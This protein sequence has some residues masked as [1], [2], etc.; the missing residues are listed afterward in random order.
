MNTTGWIGTVLAIALAVVA[1]LAQGEE[2]AEQG[3]D[4]ETMT[5]EQFGR[6]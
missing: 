5:P 1:P 2:G 4:A 3:I 6:I